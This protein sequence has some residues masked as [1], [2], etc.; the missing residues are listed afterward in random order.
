MNDNKKN[1]LV[2]KETA[3]A[4]PLKAKTPNPIA[5]RRNRIANNSNMV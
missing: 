5:N 1:I 2:M 3:I 4:I